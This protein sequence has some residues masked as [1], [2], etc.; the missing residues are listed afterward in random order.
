MLRFAPLCV[1]RRGWHGVRVVVPEWLRLGAPPSACSPACKTG[2]AYENGFLLRLE[3]Q[4]LGLALLLA[5]DSGRFF[6]PL[7]ILLADDEGCCRVL[8]GDAGGEGHGKGVSLAPSILQP[9]PCPPGLAV[10]AAR[11]VRGQESPPSNAGSTRAVASPVAPILPV[12]G[13]KERNRKCS[14]SCGRARGTGCAAG[15]GPPGKTPKPSARAR[16]VPT[17]QRQEY[18]RPTRQGCHLGK[19][20]PLPRPLFPVGRPAH[21]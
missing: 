14:E 10:G 7:E 8:H 15:Q 13:G 18:F 17:K 16:P 11:A 1:P 4:Q 19:V 3:G 5:Q 12:R 6:D 21:P 20:S 9:P 2:N